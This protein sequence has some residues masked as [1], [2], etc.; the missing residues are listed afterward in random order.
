MDF[1]NVVLP[2]HVED[3][4][5]LLI[6]SP[7]WMFGMS[8][9][10]SSEIDPVITVHCN[11]SLHWHSRSNI[12]WSVDMETELFIKSLSFKRISF[13]EIDNIPSLVSFTFVALSIDWLGFFILWVSYSNDSVILDVDKL[14]VIILEY[15]EPS[16]VGAPDLHVFCFTGTLDVPWLVV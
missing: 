11:K 3:K 1:H 6:E 14:V 13:V 4:L 5:G 7:L 10:P 16:W 15:L 8:W 9:S 12:E 2:V